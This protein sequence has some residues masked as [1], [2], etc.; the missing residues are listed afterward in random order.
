MVCDAVVQRVRRDG[1]G[2]NVEDG[3][4]GD[5][6]KGKGDEALRKIRGE[7][8]MSLVWDGASR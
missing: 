4:E 2:E 8:K 6:R 3:G 5:E 1:R 7:L